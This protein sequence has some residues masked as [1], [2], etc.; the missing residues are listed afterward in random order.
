M[1]IGV[2]GQ[3]DRARVTDA[4][5]PRG[6]I[7]AVAHQVA[8]ALLDHVAEMDADPK[9]DALVGRDPSVALDH[10]PLDFN[11]AVHCVDDAPELDDAA[12]AGALDDPAVVH[13]DG[14]IDQVASERPQPRQ[15]P[16]L[17][18]SGKPR[19]ADDVGHQD[20]RDFA[21]FP[22]GATSPRP[23]HP[24]R[25]VRAKPLGGIAKTREECDHWLEHGRAS[26]LR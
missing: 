22:H 13:G 2:L 6:N 3:A 1:A 12:V 26:M 10:R 7:D 9:F 15:N 11:G 4:L 20:R 8:V 5:D 14:R 23:C 24:F 18:G 19:I 16:V 17:V 21:R 25:V